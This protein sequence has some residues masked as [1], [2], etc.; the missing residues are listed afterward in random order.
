MSSRSVC[1]EGRGA[2]CGW[3][4]LWL[5]KLFVNSSSEMRPDPSLSNS[6][7]KARMSSS[8]GASAPC[9]R[10]TVCTSLCISEQ[11]ISPVLSTSSSRKRCWT[12]DMCFAMCSLSFLFPSPPLSMM[13]WLVGSFGIAASRS[14]SRSEPDLRFTLSL[15]FES[16]ELRML[17]MLLWR[18]GADTAEA[19]RTVCAKLGVGEAHCCPISIAAENRPRGTAW[20]TLGVGEAHCCLM[21]IVE[22][23]PRGDPSFV[24]LDVSGRE[25]AGPCHAPC[26]AAP[27]PSAPP[28]A[29]ALSRG[30]ELSTASIT[31]CGDGC[32]GV[33]APETERRGRYALPCRSVQLRARPFV[34]D[35][36]RAPCT[37]PVLSPHCK[38][39]GFVGDNGRAPSTLPVLSPRCKHRGSGSVL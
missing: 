14:F 33:T 25:A 37:L 24:A 35:N 27:T 4:R 38:H 11:S 31:L 18:K 23:R 21:S 34:G 15:T 2:A 32:S 20:A 39:R 12:R 3:M 26:T 22:N 7:K 36:G 1:T 29:A 9:S 8:S 30:A 16:I 13:V 10:K 17:L 5:R 28:S 6:S 19:N